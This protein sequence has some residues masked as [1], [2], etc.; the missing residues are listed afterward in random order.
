MT[1]KS[2]LRFV[3]GVGIAV[4]I[5]AL[6]APPLGI[7]RAQLFPPAFVYNG[8]LGKTQGVVTKAYTEMTRNIFKTGERISFVDYQFQAPYVPLL[9][10]TKPTGSGDK[11]TYA[12]TVQVAPD[13]LGHFTVGMSVPVR[14]EPTYPVISGID[15]AEGGR[16]SAQGSGLFSGWLF[17]ATGAIVI[18]YLLVG[19]LERII[20]RENY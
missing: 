7:P 13:A 1:L 4:L 19:P 9:L 16:S 3:I 8:A 14:Y 15:Q 10:G 2:F 18:G 12:G 6:A 11:V 17:W 5:F 20:L